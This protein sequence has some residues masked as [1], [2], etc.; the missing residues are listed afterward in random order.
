VRTP[1]LWTLVCLLAS[2]GSGTGN[3]LPA[4]TLDHDASGAF[5]GSWSGT[6]T[7]QI[8]GESQ[9]AEES[10][11]IAVTGRNAITFPAF[12]GDGTGPSARVTSD[13]AF[14]VGSY[15][16]SVPLDDCTVTW[17]ISN[18]TGALQN[19]MLTLTMSGVASGCGVSNVEMTIG[20]TGTK[21]V[22]SSGPPTVVLAA[23][24]VETQPNVAVTLD[25]SASTDPNGQPVTFAW[26]V[27]G[28]PAGSTPMLQGE[29][30]SKPT[31]RAD[32]E[33]TYA[34]T[35]R[36]TGTDGE[37]TTAV[38]SVQVLLSGASITALPHEVL[39]AEYSR[40]LDR[41]VMVDAASKALYV[42]DPVS[43][44]ESSVALPLPPQCLSVSP[45]G[46][47]AVVGH[48]AWISYVDLVARS[49][50]KTI[51][52]SADVGDCVLAGNGWA[53]LFPR[54]DQWVALHSVL[55]STGTDTTS[56]ALLYAGARA[57]LHPDGTRIYS[58]TTEL[59]PANIDRWDITG[60]AA[61]H[62]WAS[63][64][65]GNYSMGPN[66]WVS[67]DGALL[68]TAS[69]TAF[70]TSTTQTSDMVYGGTLEGLTLVEH[71]DS[72]ISEIAAIPGVDPYGAPS[73]TT[74][75]ATVELFDTQYLATTGT[76][77][78]PNWAVGT[79]A[80]ITHGRFVFY[81]AD[82]SKRYVIVQADASSGLV[83]DTA[84]LS[85]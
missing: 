80:F 76:I 65:W 4:D 29:T 30:T 81:S 35:V 23:S 38:V 31:F 5:A 58:I 22:A 47:H 73:N 67:R 7:A 50:V 10:L 68:L 48:D 19:G 37:S 60:G 59:S 13:S 69:A 12:C 55:L 61:A 8:A 27:T 78:L 2:C 1:V 20:F 77:A 43:A 3:N 28:Q 44:A 39:R 62:A 57:R 70:R 66:I 33:G 79:N 21:S 64:Y 32:L 52:V 36:V 40:G 74:A 11:A 53:Y 71:L 6:A 16:C 84:V 41:I 49:L 82:G 83:H 14:T 34:V 54:V 75:D 26:T 18:G 42:Y 24:N 46:T 85:Y 15:A 45:D 25:A 63:P 72:S 56:P 17:N 9:S 51:P